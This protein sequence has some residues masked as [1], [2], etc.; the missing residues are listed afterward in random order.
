MNQ[1]ASQLSSP[2]LGF[3]SLL[4]QAPQALL[5]SS[6]QIFFFF[7]LTTPFPFSWF[8][9]RILKPNPVT[10]SVMCFHERVEVSCSI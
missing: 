8:L 2:G 4:C 9:R 7:F 6:S 10:V 5:L 1:V 3:S